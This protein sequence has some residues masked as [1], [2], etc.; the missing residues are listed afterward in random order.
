MMTVMPIILSMPIEQ[1]T[2]S[3]DVTDVCALTTTEVNSIKAAIAG[4]ENKLC[5]FNMTL[6]DILNSQ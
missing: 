3:N 2:D 5:R 6:D 1:G 4:H